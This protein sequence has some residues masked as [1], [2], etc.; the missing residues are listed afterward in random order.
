[1]DN[2]SEYIVSKSIDEWTQYKPPEPD[3][4]YCCGV[5]VSEGVAGGDYSVATIWDKKTGEEIAIYRGEAMAPDRFGTL[6]NKWGR[7]Y[8]DALLVIESN[9][10][11]LTTVTAVKNLLY[12]NIYFR[13][14]KFGAISNKWSENF[15]WKTSMVT[16]PLMIDDLRQAL[17]EGSLIPHSEL[18]LNEMLTF[19]FDE[20]GRMV[21]QAAFHDDIIFSS[22]IALQGFK[23]L[24]DPQN[25]GQINID[26]M[27]FH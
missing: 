16:R 8:N 20:A 2:G 5:D 10:H 25:L 18:L 6:L 26:N 12:P 3:H 17:H 21:T 27:S 7:M 15:G 1:L 4:S 24:A 19:V 23:V 11:G 13:P 14:S 9:N 22:A